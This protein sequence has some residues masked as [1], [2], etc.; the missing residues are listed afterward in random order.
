MNTTPFIR[1]VDCEEY[2]SRVL[3]QDWSVV[4]LATRVRVNRLTAD[5]LNPAV[6]HPGLGGIWSYTPV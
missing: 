3:Q 1:A 5:A 6:V 4:P 2:L